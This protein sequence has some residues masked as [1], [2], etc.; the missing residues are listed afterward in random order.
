M[1][2]ILEF[3]DPDTSAPV[4][5][6]YGFGKPL[7]TPSRECDYLAVI[8]YPRYL[9]KPVTRTELVELVTRLLPLQTPAAVE[10]AIERLASKG[11]TIDAPPA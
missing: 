9:L 4:V 5:E 8:W 1:E 10:G 3:V 11:I 7:R 6:F 2:F